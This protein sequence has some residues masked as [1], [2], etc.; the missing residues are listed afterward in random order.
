MKT[1][2]VSSFADLDRCFEEFHRFQDWVY[3]GQAD[4]S[5]G[6]IPKL[7]RAPIVEERALFTVSIGYT[8]ESGAMA[9]PFNIL[10]VAE[11]LRKARSDAAL[12]IER[13]S[14]TEWERL[15]YP[16]LKKRT[17]NDWE[18]LAMGQHYELMT[19]LLDWTENP[20]AAAFFAL[21]EAQEAPAAIYALRCTRRLDVRLRL[22]DFKGLALYAPRRSFD[23]VIRQDSLFS[24]SEDPCC[25]LVEQL[26]GD[27]ELV[28]F[29]IPAELRETLLRKVVSFGID[30]STL[31]PDLGGVAYHINWRLNRPG[32]LAQGD[33]KLDRSQILALQR[34]KALLEPRP[35]ASPP[36]PSTADGEAAA[37]V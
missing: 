12:A 32:L 33:P 4:A 34:F 7:A 20:L 37:E 5:W 15:S 9:F 19:R 26:E 10:D 1:R 29:V 21:S 14:L 3:R 35:P 18:L 13:Q 25:N 24:V 6:L 31:F 8:A 23:R 2:D 30:R 27:A 16:Y 11:R 22:A 36:N 17:E 28:K